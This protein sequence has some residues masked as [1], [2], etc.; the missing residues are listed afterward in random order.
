MSK[1]TSMKIKQGDT[2]LVRTGKDAGKKG[3]VTRAFPQ[4][5]KVL[6]EGVNVMKKHVRA[7]MRDAKGQTIEKAM[8]VHVSNVALVDEKTGKAGRVGYEMKDG[9]KL[10][11]VKVKK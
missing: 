1:G 8:P 9:K 5:E 2:V 11:I 3:V 10:R 6:I 7:R 4:D